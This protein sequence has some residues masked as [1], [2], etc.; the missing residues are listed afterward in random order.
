MLSIELF[1]RGGR[2]LDSLHFDETLDLTVFGGRLAAVWVASKPRMI[3]RVHP[4]SPLVEKKTN[5]T[6]GGA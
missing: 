1:L 3:S 4:L 6:C 2:L 5:F